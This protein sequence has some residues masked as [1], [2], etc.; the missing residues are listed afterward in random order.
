MIPL[1]SITDIAN[2]DVSKIRS[3]G[4]KDFREALTN[5]KATVN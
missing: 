3:T 2:I 1:R 5:V 4:I